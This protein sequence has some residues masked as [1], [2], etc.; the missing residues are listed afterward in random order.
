MD[1]VCPGRSTKHGAIVPD[2]IDDG[3]HPVLGTGGHDLNAMTIRSP[4]RSEIATKS[5]HDHGDDEDN[6]VLHGGSPLSFVRS[7]SIVTDYATLFLA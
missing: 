6:Q 2:A 5:R 3:A 4:G 7:G 1:L